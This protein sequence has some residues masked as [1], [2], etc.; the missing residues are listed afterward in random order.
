MTQGDE[1]AFVE[2]VKRALDE[3]ERDLDSTTLARLRAV[4]QRALANYKDSRWW[5]TPTGWVPAGALAAALAG[6]AIAAFM[7]LSVPPSGLPPTGIE[8]LELLAAQDSIEFYADL[9]F[10]YWLTTHSDAG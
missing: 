10:Y 5:R 8:D 7:W 2:T 4:R 1:K 3:L 6:V 9:D